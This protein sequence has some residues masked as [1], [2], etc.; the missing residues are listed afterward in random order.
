MSY[1]SYQYNMFTIDFLKYQ[2]WITELS[3]RSV[4]VDMWYKLFRAF[5]CT[6]RLKVENRWSW[7]QCFKMVSKYSKR[8]GERNFKKLQSISAN[9]YRSKMKLRI[10]ALKELIVPQNLMVC[11][12]S[13]DIY[14]VLTRS[15]LMQIVWT[16]TLLPHL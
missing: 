12:V 13:V 9:V 1:S 16:V 4:I 6:L 14:L 10:E 5:W 15:K 7:K 11:M 2:P 8:R 3:C